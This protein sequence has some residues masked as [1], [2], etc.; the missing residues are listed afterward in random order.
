MKEM[1]N[2]PTAAEVINACPP[3]GD[4][5]RG[6]GDMEV[7][8]R[9]SSVRVTVSG[10]N[11]ALPS[12]LFPFRLL[13]VSPSQQRKKKEG[14]WSRES[15]QRRWRKRRRGGLRSQPMRRS[16]TGSPGFEI[17]PHCSFI[18]QG[19][20][21]TSMVEHAF[22]YREDRGRKRKKE[23]RGWEGRP[24]NVSR[25]SKKPWK[26]DAEGMVA[27]ETESVILKVFPKSKDKRKAEENVPSSVFKKQPSYQ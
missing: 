18:P 5:Q 23:R 2:S 24:Y 6:R 20:C 16:L 15:V 7:H 17:S 10:S 12:P 27:M 8:K 21:T 9:S 11:T 1:L 22:A 3:T 19:G 13:F 25:D 4:A 26:K 14:G